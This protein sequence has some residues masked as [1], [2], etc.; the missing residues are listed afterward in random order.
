M[1]ASILLRER[2]MHMNAL[3]YILGLLLWNGHTSKKVSSK[4][5]LL[6]MHYRLR[7]LIPYP[8]FVD[9]GEI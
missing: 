9:C 3:Q 5:Y 6:Y 4:L 2:N 8:Y 1:I 7:D